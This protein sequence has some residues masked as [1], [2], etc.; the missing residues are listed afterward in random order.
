MIVGC[1]CLQPDSFWPLLGGFDRPDQNV[2]I[3]NAS[4]SRPCFFLFRVW[5]SGFPRESHRALGAGAGSCLPSRHAPRRRNGH[6]HLPWSS[7]ISKAKTHAGSSFGSI[8]SGFEVELANVL[9]PPLAATGPSA[10][11]CSWVPVAFQKIG[12]R[13]AGFHLADSLTPM[14]PTGQKLSK[15]EILEGPL[16]HLFNVP[17]VFL[18]HP[19]ITVSEESPGPISRQNLNMLV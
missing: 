6:S 2:R 18:L 1:G 12:G 7:R 15:S 4:G 9:F 19:G 11:C 13:D 5:A 8:L 17:R 3:Q 14:F 16:N 10:D